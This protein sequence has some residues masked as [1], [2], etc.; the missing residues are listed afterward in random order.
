MGATVFVGVADGKKSV[1]WKLLLN[2]VIGW[3]VTLLFAALLSAGIFSFVAY[4]P[5]VHA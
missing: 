4:S 3:V 1:N 5:S 2:T